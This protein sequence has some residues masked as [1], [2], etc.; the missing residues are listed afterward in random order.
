MAEKNALARHSEHYSL[1]TLKIFDFE[2]ATVAQL[3]AHPIG[4]QEVA[5]S[6][7][8]GRQDLLVEI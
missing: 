2:P 7:P 6:T 4:V 3:N 5:G 1:W 8:A